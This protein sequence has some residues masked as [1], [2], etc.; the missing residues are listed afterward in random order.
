MLFTFDTDAAVYLISK[1]PTAKQR[2]NARRKIKEIACK[3]IDAEIE[4]KRELIRSMR[5]ESENSKRGVYAEISKLERVK[6]EMNAG[7]YGF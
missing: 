1:L 3:S 4:K 6:L 7:E 5:S 2:I